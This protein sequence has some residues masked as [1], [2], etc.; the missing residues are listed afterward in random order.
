ML[1]LAVDSAVDLKSR[2]LQESACGRGSVKTQSEEEFWGPLT[3]GEVEKI[4]PGSI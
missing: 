4:D 1:H 2:R 3:L